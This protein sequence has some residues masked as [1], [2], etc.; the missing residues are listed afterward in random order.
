MSHRRG[1]LGPYKRDYTYTYYNEQHDQY[2]GIDVL[3]I[4]CGTLSNAFEQVLCL[5]LLRGAGAISDLL[6]D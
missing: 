5:A 4:E 3:S 6:R 1:D 2:R